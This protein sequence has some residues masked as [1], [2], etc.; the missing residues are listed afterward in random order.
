MFRKFQIWVYNRSTHTYPAQLKRV[1][2]GGGAIAVKTEK[3]N[4]HI[5]IKNLDIKLNFL[6]NT[7]V[8]LKV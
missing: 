3:R 5:S 7:L 6:L 4:Y 2:Y 1:L 8:W